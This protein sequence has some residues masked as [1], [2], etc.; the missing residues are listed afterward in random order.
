MPNVKKLGLLTPW[1]RERFGELGILSFETGRAEARRGGSRR[2]FAPGGAKRIRARPAR[3]PALAADLA[4]VAS[5]RIV[6]LGTSDA[7]TLGVLTRNLLLFIVPMA[8][9]CSRPAPGTRAHD[10]SAVG[11]RAEAASHQAE[12][13]ATLV[14]TGSKAYYESVHRE[15]QRL[16]AAHLRAAQQL[17]A[18]YARACEGRP[19]DEGWPEI[20]SADEVPGGVVLH[21]TPE[22]GSADEV[23][24]KL[25]C[26]RASLALN[27]F[28]HYPE[29]PLAVDAIDVIVH[30]EPGG[31]AVMF[32]V[33]GD[34][35]VEELRRR[36][37]AIARAD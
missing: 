1:L 4:R 14:F 36:A 34:A 13:D 24:A 33:E 27:G 28:D 8:L 16:A 10:D 20:A 22:S 21:L 26:R 29:D 23:M 3:V 6:D 37:E 12:A 2:R 35:D 17:E 18:E 19:R 31:T 11:H 7:T 25:E 30:A 5:A 9:A 15:H 32:G